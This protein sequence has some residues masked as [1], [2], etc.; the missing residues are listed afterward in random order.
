MADRPD[1]E[2]L[3]GAFVKLAAIL[4]VGFI[5]PVLDLTIVNVAVATIGRDLQASV[6]TVQWVMSAFLLAFAMVIPISGWAM[7]RLGGKRL[8]LG[9]LGL[10]LVGSVL[11]ALSWN[12]DS[13]IA[14]RV[15]QGAAAG[16]M[17]P[18][19][20][21]LIVQAT[22]GRALGRA[23]ALAT[24]PALIGPMLGPVIG[25]L[26][27]SHLSWHW[28]F[29]VNVPFAVAGLLWAWRGLP[30]DRRGAAQR[31]DVLGL[32]L[33]SPAAAAL[34]YALTEV[35]TKGGFAHDAVLVPLALGLALLAAFI[36][37]ALRTSH[38]PL[39]DLR[40]FGRRSFAAS[41]SLLFLSGFAVYGAMLLMPL[42]FQELRDQ[43]ALMAGLLL[44][45]QGAGV[46]L[47]RGLAGRLTDR[48]GARPIVLVGLALTVAGTFAYTQAG[49]HTSELLLACSLVVRGAGVG[50]LTIPA[51]A[52][53]YLGLRPDRIP[54]ATSTTRLVQQ[55]GGSFGAAV[56]AVVLQTQMVAHANGSAGLA[57]A[58]SHTFWWSLGLAALAAVPALLLP[59]HV[60][61]RKPVGVQAADDGPADGEVPVAL[62]PAD[63][64][65][66]VDQG[67]SARPRVPMARSSV[68]SPSEGGAQ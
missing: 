21:N 41:T 22:G 51:T 44:A 2:R 58:F 3:G 11:C 47:T 15:V 40:L 10:F 16:L 14:F 34:I 46:L 56:I 20:Q 8:W 50:M 43:S 12:M 9:S 52:T 64:V 29:W 4:L 5:A 18:V 45:P 7:A 28:I 48:V 24:L 17:L 39:I 54:H 55:I 67:A 42:Y 26:I 53:A 49:L 36:F 13:L 32:V 35:A 68:E 23:M 27:V 38:E 33:L 30:A 63:S 60:T 59:S 37:H 61:R 62:S 65:E 57:L 31:L 19:F 66:P 25:G 1:N 6:A